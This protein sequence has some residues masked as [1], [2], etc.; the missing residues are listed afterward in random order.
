MIYD[1]ANT[2]SVT[3]YFDAI[4]ML[5]F[6]TDFCAW[7]KQR[8]ERHVH[9]SPLGDREVVVAALNRLLRLAFVLVKKQTFYQLP[10]TD[11][12]EIAT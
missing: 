10:Q 4:R 9:A 11:L 2:F 7:A 12:V 6:N 3:V 5:R 8:R 1:T